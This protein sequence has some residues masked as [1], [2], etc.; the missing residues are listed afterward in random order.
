M[1]NI[2]WNHIN[3][4]DY[5]EEFDQILISSHIQN[6]IWII[7]HSTTTREAA[8]HS[9]G[10][11]GK[12]GDLLYRWG[13][14]QVYKAGTTN[15]QMLFGQHDAQWVKKGYPGEGHITIF[16]NGYLRPE[17]SYSSIEEIVPPVDENGN[18]FL[19]PSF[20]FGPKEPIWNYTSENPSDFYSPFMSGAQR[21][22]NGNTLICDGI[23]GVFFEVTAEKKIVWRYNNLYP[24]LNSK[25]IKEV[26]NIKRYPLDYP[27]IKDIAK[28]KFNIDDEVTNLYLSELL[29]IITKLNNNRY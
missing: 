7:D 11:F 4:L 5:N 6:E 18:Y 26:A 1:G 22:S 23:S 29:S 15:D 19:E 8:G 28:N 16:N 13:N 17:L 24:N 9:G 2:D 3:S 21:L 12:G 25:I 10:R 20:V 27:G 14:P